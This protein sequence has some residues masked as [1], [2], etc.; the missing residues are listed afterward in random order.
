MI[1]AA[2][3]TSFKHYDEYVYVT[4]EGA[5]TTPP[6]TGW[7]KFGEDMTNY[8]TQAYVA[9]QLAQFTPTKVQAIA[10]AP[11]TSYA[12]TAVAGTGSQDLIQTEIRYYK[13]NNKNFMT[14]DNEQVTTGLF[15]AID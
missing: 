8:A 4:S 6:Y 13:Q 1:D 2:A 14:I 15:Y 5:T 9:T 7:E 10:A 3:P 11:D 12:M